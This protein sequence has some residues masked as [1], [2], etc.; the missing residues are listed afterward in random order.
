MHPTRTQTQPR[1]HFAF[2]RPRRERLTDQP[3]TD[4]EAPSHDL[5]GRENIALG[6][7]QI[8]HAAQAT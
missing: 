7:D 5:S 4:R 1:R 8:I 6:P 3:V 2:G